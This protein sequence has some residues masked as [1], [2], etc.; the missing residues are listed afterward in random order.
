MATN[1]ACQ[2]KKS[3]IGLVKFQVN[4]DAIFIQAE[5]LTM[6]LMIKNSSGPSKQFRKEIFI[7]NDLYC[8]WTYACICVIMC[9]S[10]WEKLQCAVI[11]S[12]ITFCRENGI[13]RQCLH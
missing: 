13:K 10:N 6:S 3:K 9:T 2:E 1:K 8:A 5:N 7:C 12:Q 11:A 4:V